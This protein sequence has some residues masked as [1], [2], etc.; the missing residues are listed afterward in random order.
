VGRF[1]NLTPTWP[2][3]GETRVPRA[4]WHT[5]GLVVALLLGYLIWRGYQSPDFLLDLAAFRL[6]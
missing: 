4:V 3:A 2:L 5:I 6:C 1:E